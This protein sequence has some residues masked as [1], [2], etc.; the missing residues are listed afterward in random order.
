LPSDEI[1]AVVLAGGESTRLGRDKAQ[2]L[3]EGT[4]LLTRAAG[5]AGR[6][7]REVYISGRDPGELAPGLPWFADATPRI[8]PMGG[9]ITALALLGRPVLALSCDVPFLTEELLGKLLSA[10]ADRGPGQV[11]TVYLHPD[12]GYVESLAAIYEPEA[13]GYLRAALAEGMYK[14]SRAI[15]FEV[16]NHVLCGPAEA[17]LF[18]NV[19]RPED[20]AR[21]GDF[22]A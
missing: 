10:R 18:F 8:G 7:C 6:V 1:V 22:S 3:V 13:L 9:I 2:V 20:L 19:N 15:P 21:L 16:R 14:L 17:A 11:M 5:L 4:A 12:T